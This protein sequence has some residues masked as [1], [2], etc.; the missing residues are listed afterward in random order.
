MIGAVE[1]VGGLDDVT[2]DAPSDR[3]AFDTPNILWHLGALTASFAGVVVVSRIHPSARG[4][5][6]LLGALVLL[7]VFAG[8][9]EVLRRRGW[10]VPCGVIAAT[11]LIFVPVVVG[12][13]EKLIGV[14]AQSPTAPVSQFQGSAF[15]I[16]LATVAAGLGVYWLTR[17]PFVFAYVTFATLVSI[18]LLTPVVVSN[19][20]PSDNATIALL[21]GIAFLVVGA[22]ADRRGFRREAFWWHI[23]GLVAMSVGVGYHAFENTS[24]GWLLVL[25]VFAAVLALAVPFR[26]AT[27]GLFGVVGTYAAL[28]HY[29]Y[30]W[31]GTLGTAFSLTLVGL[32]LVACGLALQRAGDSLPNVLADWSAGA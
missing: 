17:Y 3:A 10:I 7:A 13:F 24:F 27:W 9:S 12:A 29:A 23:V 31:F 28:A 30:V 26:R 14:L 19:P 32:G 5:W 25:I 11:S 18:E 2:A 8:V 20:S 22:A 16:A 4:L 1:S 21:T 6:I 15:V